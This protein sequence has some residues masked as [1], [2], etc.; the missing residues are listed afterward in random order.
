MSNANVLFGMGMAILGVIWLIMLAL[1]ILILIAQWHIFKKA[2]Q[3]GWAAIIPVYNVYVLTRIVWGNGWIFLL[4]FLPVG[5][6]VFAICTSVKLARSFGKS[7]GFAAGLVFLPFVF[8]P[9]LGFGKAEYEGPSQSG[10]K[11]MIIGSVITGVVGT[12][13]L[14]LVTVIAAMSI[15]TVPDY[16]D[17]DYSTS[18]DLSVPEDPFS[19]NTPEG[20]DLADDTTAD[21]SSDTAPAVTGEPIDGYDNFIMATLNN[22]DIAVTFPLLDSKTHSYGEGAM[23]T[24]EANGISIELTIGY[25]ESSDPAAVVSD[26]AKVAMSV[27]EDLSNFYRDVAIS[28]MITGDGFALQ[29]IDYNYQGFDGELYPCIE[30]IKCDIVNGY[31][32][33]INMTLNNYTADENT[34]ALFASACELYGIDFE[35]AE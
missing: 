28:D 24:A 4:L 14:V 25:G 29:Q 20:E 11:G 5:N 19:G 12:V 34:K 7:G 3:H 10:K 6:I 18:A 2:G 23:L 35:F 16:E 32:I 33:T 27:F 22:G 21:S 26:D 17:Y 15:Q 31:P 13:L 9:M 1:G 30:L 8:M